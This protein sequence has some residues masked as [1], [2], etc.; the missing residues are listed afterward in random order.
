MKFYFKQVNM[1][2]TLFEKLLDEHDEDIVRIGSDVS[3]FDAKQMGVFYHREKTYSLLEVIEDVYDDGG[4]IIFKSGIALA[5]ML[6]F[7]T[8][9]LIILDDEETYYKVI[10][11][12]NE[13]YFET[14]GQQR[15]DFYLDESSG[16]FMI[17]QDKPKRD[18]H[19]HES[20]YQKRLRYLHIY[21]LITFLGII[22][23]IVISFI[24]H[25]I[26]GDSEAADAKGL[27]IIFLTLFVLLFWHSRRLLFKYCRRCGVPLIYANKTYLEKATYTVPFLS[28]V[29]I[30]AEISLECENCSHTKSFK[31]FLKV[32]DKN[33]ITNI[34]TEISTHEAVNKYLAKRLKV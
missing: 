9:E 11:M 34:Y 19:K 13:L 20:K 25:A 33:P 16:F 22:I 24:I 3:T 23:S 12:Y 2:K 6:N 1:G 28:S 32:V 7:D 18:A 10:D 26:I 27:P 15:K 31:R 17:Q 14:T 5:F 30:S 8:D 29:Y 4:S 21:S